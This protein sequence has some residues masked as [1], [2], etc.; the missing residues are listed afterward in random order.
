MAT[1]TNC[2]APAGKGVVTMAILLFFL[3]IAL[4]SA[5]GWVA[6]TRDSADWKP[7][8]DGVRAPAHR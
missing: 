5:A 7:T 3:L 1:G 4:I 2:S 8:S 6:D